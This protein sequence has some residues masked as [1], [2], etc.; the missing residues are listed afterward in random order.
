MKYVL[1]IALIVSGCAT[2][3]QTKPPMFPDC[4]ELAPTP[5]KMKKGETISKLEVR[6]ELS[7]E[8]S[9]NRH[10]ACIDTVSKM[11]DYISKHN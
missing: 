11:Q 2:S 6:I 10:A 1:L 7:R 9:V 4:P 3:I 5:A 8:D